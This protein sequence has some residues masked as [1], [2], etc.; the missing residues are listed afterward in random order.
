MRWGAA[1]LAGATALAKAARPQLAGQLA[2]SSPGAAQGSL[3][4]QQEWVHT[5]MSA[6]SRLVL[7]LADHRRAIERR[8]A[9]YAQYADGLGAVE[10]GRPL[11][12]ELPP[13][14][15]PYVFPFI[16][17]TPDIIYPALRAAGVPVYRWEDVA[18]EPCATARYYKTRLV[19]FPCHQSLEQQE[20]VD[21]IRTIRQVLATC[22]DSQFPQPSLAAP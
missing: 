11:R 19:Q 13:G 15:V 17:S 9:I 14:V 21:L 5:P 12:R 8:R 20:V 22:S 2:D 7:R 16:L 6:A 4:F 1:L 3:G 10:G 18:E